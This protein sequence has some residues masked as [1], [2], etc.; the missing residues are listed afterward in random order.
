MRVNQG[1]VTSP[2]Q[3]RDGSPLR[4]FNGDL[5]RQYTPYGCALDPWE[6]LDLVAPL[7][8]RN[9]EDALAAVR[10]KNAEHAYRRDI[11]VSSQNNLLRMD[12]SRFGGSEQKVAEIVS[13]PGTGDTHGCPHGHVQICFPS[14]PAKLPPLDLERLLP[15]QISRLLVNQDFRRIGLDLDGLQFCQTITSFSSSTP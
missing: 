14:F 3:K 11:V 6:R 7:V 2:A 8:Q 12:E 5:I 1:Q 4:N 13:R 9:A 10:G 15:P